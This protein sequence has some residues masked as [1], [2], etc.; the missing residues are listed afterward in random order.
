MSRYG[1]DFRAQYR[2][3][4]ATIAKTNE[5][6]RKHAEK[7][8]SKENNSQTS[9]GNYDAD[10]GRGF[11]GDESGRVSTFS[12][13]ESG[14]KVGNT[15]RVNAVN[16]VTNKSQ[17]ANSCSRSAVINA[18]ARSTSVQGAVSGQSAGQGTK[19]AAASSSG[20]SNGGQGG[21]ST[22]GGQ[23]G[24]NASGQSGGGQGR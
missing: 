6:G 15:N 14:N 13:Q 4:E 9:K 12:S 24:G 11:R 23:S 18:N 7:I 16:S 1:E 5:I 19:G 2:V 20:Q 21:G 22:G 8:N 3:D 17:A 10:C